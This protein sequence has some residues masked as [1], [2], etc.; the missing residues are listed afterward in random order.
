MA[1]KTDRLGRGKGSK[2]AKPPLSDLSCYAGNVFVENQSERAFRYEDKNRMQDK[3]SAIQRE[4]NNSIL[5][6]K[7]VENQEI[8]GNFLEFSRS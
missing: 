3:L 1:E 6:L 4:P 2:P 7:S 5:F 8:N